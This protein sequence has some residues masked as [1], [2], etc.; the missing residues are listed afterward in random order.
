MGYCS[1]QA[2]VDKAQAVEELGY[3]AFYASDHL[4][5]VAGAPPNAPFLEP[6]T[7][8]AAIAA[9]T[10]KLRLGCLVAGVTYRH[11]AILAKLAATV[12]AISG[13]R[14]EVG[15]GAGWSSADHVAYGLPF[16]PLRERLERLEETLQILDGIWT[17]QPFSF[18]GAHYRFRD[19]PF[20][21]PPV[22]KPR[23]PFLLAGA[24]PRLLRLTA[25]WADH[26]VSLSTPDFARSCIERIGRECRALGRDPAEIEHGL[27]IG[28]LLSSDPAEVE[29]ALRER[30]L[31]APAGAERAQGRT[32]LEGESGEERARAS[33]LAGSPEQVRE[34]I[35]RYLEAGVTHF[36]LLTPPPF[37]PGLLERFRDQVIRTLPA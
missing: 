20:S 31:P 3:S 19:A 23:P 25:R 22:Q 33:L 26:W 21:P 1:V 8:L 5:G 36:I 9:K 32:A 28:L 27:S 10:E 35:G 11:P 18:D 2:L 7:L 6:W 12:D 16:P 14:L 37:D 4:H 30:A 34:R 13:G 29:R 17:R 15:L 24:S